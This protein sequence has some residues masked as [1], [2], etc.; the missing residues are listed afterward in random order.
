V[1][2]R[3]TDAEEFMPKMRMRDASITVAVGLCALPLPTAAQ[4]MLSEEIA[5]QRTLSREGIA[6]R[7]EA[8]RTASAAEIDVIGPLD[9]PGVELSRESA[10]GESEWQLGVVQPIDLNGRRGS[11]REAARAETQAMDADIERRRQLLVADVR[12]AY[13]QCAAATAELDIWERYVGQL[14]E[15]ER[16]S[17]ARAEAGDT[18]VYDVRRVRVEQRSAEAQL[19]QARGE[20]AAGCSSLA[21]L[22]GIESPQVE[23][24]AIA[25]L[26]NALE[27]GE[28]SDLLAQEQR[29]LAASHR[30]SAAER[31]RL[32]QIAVGAGLKR[33]DDGMDTAYGPVVSLGATLP[34][35]NGGGAA[36]RREEARRAA[37]EAELLISRRRVEAEQR[38][39]AARASAAREAAVTASRAQGDAG[40]LGIIA[41]TA[42]Q[43]GEIGVV[44]LL[45][46]Y[47]AARDAELS[48]IALA[49]NAAQAAVDYDLATGRTYE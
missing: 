15:A 17:S 8:D 42:Y 33:V 4:E 28:R 44:E 6:A 41:E 24:A 32:P 2:G 43:A 12:G 49:L 22:T 26:T 34:I 36:V 40:R 14:G 29:I 7:D 25:Q 31:A 37:L 3:Q 9:N 11:L 45:D 5:I 48:V 39:A 30:V 19:A 47:E 18:A 38:A 23:L 20:S 46:A 1:P 13:V 35:W 10:G 16:V 27:L 21:A